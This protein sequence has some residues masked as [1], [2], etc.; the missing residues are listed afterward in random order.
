MQFYME[1][2]DDMA[3]YPPEMSWDYVVNELVDARCFHPRTP[4]VA[5]MLMQRLGDADMVLEVLIPW[6]ANEVDLWRWNH[7]RM[8]VKEAL[9]L[10]PP[11]EVEIYLGEQL[12]CGN[13]DFV[14][15]S[16]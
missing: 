1:F 16:A 9:R 8:H 15:A 3:E 12:I 2:D 14:P 13:V 7:M 4:Y 10:F 5:S 11:D 6:N